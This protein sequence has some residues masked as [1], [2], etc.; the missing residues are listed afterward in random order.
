MCCY[1][2]HSEYLIKYILN[3]ACPFIPPSLCLYVMFS[4]ASLTPLNPTCIRFY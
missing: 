1:Q 4:P 3:T 2:K